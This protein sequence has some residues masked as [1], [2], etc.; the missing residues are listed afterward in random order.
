[1]EFGV[2]AYA[3]GVVPA[4]QYG[5]SETTVKLDQSKRCK[6]G[7]AAAVCQGGVEAGIAA[8]IKA[9]SGHSAGSDCDHESQEDVKTIGEHHGP[10]GGV[11]W[12][13]LSRSA[14][15]QRLRTSVATRYIYILYY[16]AFE[17]TFRGPTRP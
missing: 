11:G 9:L 8:L 14:G 5:G 13:R 7:F 2:G 17:K 3:G 10:I 4:K 12:G 16:V 1:M 6:H 15:M